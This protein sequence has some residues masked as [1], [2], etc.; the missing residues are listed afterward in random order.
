VC[1]PGCGW[2]NPDYEAS[3]RGEGAQEGPDGV[4]FF[5]F[6]EEVAVERMFVNDVR[7]Y[8][9]CFVDTTGLAEALGDGPIPNGTKFL[10]SIGQA[11]FGLV[12]DFERGEWSVLHVDLEFE[13]LP[14]PRAIGIDAD[15]PFRPQASLRT[16]QGLGPRCDEKTFLDE[17]AVVVVFDRKRHE[18]VPGL[19][20]FAFAVE[21]AALE[22]GALHF[23]GRS[24]AAADAIQIGRGHARRRDHEEQEQLL[25][26]HLVRSD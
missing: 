6:E 5:V 13:S 9:F 25:I 20:V 16:V 21:P 12:E 7:G 22:D 15:D 8:R 23:D 1:P 17:L 26:G 10:Q 14:V 3:V 24:A 11:F 18:Q 19:E 2:E 4:K